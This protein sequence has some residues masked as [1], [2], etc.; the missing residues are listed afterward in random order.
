VLYED[1]PHMWDAWDIDP[2]YE[3]KPMPV[4]SEPTS[5]EIVSDDPLRCAVR[6]VRPLGTG[7]TI[8]QT[9]TLDAASPRV[10]V[11]CKVQW[12]EHRTLLRVL[13]PTT[14][15]CDHATYEVQ[16][17]AVKRPT[18]RST[19][20]DAA[21]FEVCAHRWMDYSERGLGLA[22]INDS[23]YGHSCHDGVMGLSL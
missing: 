14:I 20:W 1:V 15:E 4:D 2:S 11:H 17:G 8:E 3:H 16:F 10:E 18:H 12:Q 23:K 21:K 6:I 5:V 9:I 13:F 7:S 19:T 22:L